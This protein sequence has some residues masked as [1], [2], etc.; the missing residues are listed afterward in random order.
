LN[1]DI[2]HKV[3]RTDTVLDVIKDIKN[4]CRGDPTEQIKTQI[5]GQTILTSY[6]KRTY[7]VD[8]I[9][10]SMSPLDTFTEDHEEGADPRSTNYV[11][12]YQ[13]KYGWETKET[14]QP[15]IISIHKKTGNRLVLIPELCQMTGL[16]DSMRANF[17]LMKAMGNHTHADA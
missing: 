11:D 1:I 5:Q 15:V 10:F 17:Q 14:N 2:I 9:D 13:R 7:R 6:N 12:Y 16:S 8:E 3:L 4:R